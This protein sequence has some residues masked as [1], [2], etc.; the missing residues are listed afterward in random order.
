[1]KPWFEKEADILKFPEPEKKVITMP[2]VASYPDFL[3]GVKDLHNRKDKGEISQASHDKLYQDLIHRFMKKES[4]E[5]PWFLREAPSTELL[6]MI[7][8]RLNDPNIDEKT[9]QKVL[10][11]LEGSGLK[12]RLQGV[13]ENDPDAKKA[14]TTV[15]EQIFAAKP[16][17]ED[18]DNFIKAYPKGLVNIQ[19]LTEPGKK[20]WSQIFVG[21]TGDNH[22]T[23]VVDRLY[24]VKNQGIGP[25][26]VCL[27][28]L[29]PQIFHSGS[30]PGAGDIYIDGAGHFEIKA[31]VAKPGRLFDGRKAKVDLATLQQV[32]EQLG[33]E[34]P[35][36][37]IKDLIAANPNQ[38]QV[39]AIAQSIFRHVGN[40]VAGFVNAVMKKDE[41]TAKLEHTKLAYV[42]YQ[43]MSA[44]GDDKFVG[45]IF[46]SLKGKWSNVVRNIDELVQNLAVGTIYVMSPDQND[47]FP[48]TTFK[49]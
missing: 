22:M 14:I 30:R 4:F 26:E 42:N 35:R 38:K 15:T 31:S 13:L 1:M 25:A 48:Q 16:T 20:D 37:N 21:Y 45:V 44:A 29:S 46:M 17:T 40:N 9:L 10:M 41:A 24:Q 49:F 19:A 43:N 28:V 3:T 27:S 23:R 33:I 47:L 36:V 39:M 6:Q 18:I 5:K 12:Q 34:K 11:A 7:K 2:N 32:K 8:D